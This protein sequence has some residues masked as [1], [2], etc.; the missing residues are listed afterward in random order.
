MS[1]FLSQPS[2]RAPP[3]LTFP[4]KGG[5]NNEPLRA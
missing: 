4:H 3:S 5:G 1:R 2:R